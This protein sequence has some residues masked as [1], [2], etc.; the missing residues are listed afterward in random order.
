[1][2]G[3]R[4]VGGLEPRLWLDCFFHYVIVGILERRTAR[5]IVVDFPRWPIR[6][7]SDKSKRA[8]HFKKQRV[9]LRRVKNLDCPRIEDA[10]IDLGD[11]SGYLEANVLMEG[12]VR[13][14]ALGLVH[15]R[16]SGDRVAE[17][18]AAD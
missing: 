16:I 14:A 8:N 2:F 7:F 4:K 15:S 11:S 17:I 1:M 10:G 6:H 13:R 5:A 3:A 12:S 9:H 18:D